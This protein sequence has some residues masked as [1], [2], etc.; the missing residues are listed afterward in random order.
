M[1]SHVN[2]PTSRIGRAGPSGY[3]TRDLPFRRYSAVL[4]AGLLLTLTSTGMVAQE[5]YPPVE[6]DDGFPVLPA[7]KSNQESLKLPA[8][9][10]AKTLLTPFD[11]S[12][13]MF[14]EIA[15][16]NTIHQGVMRVT[17]EGVS[18]GSR[19]DLLVM[20]SP[21]AAND[22]IAY[23]VIDDGDGTLSCKIFE[24]KVNWRVPIP[25]LLANQECTCQGVNNVIG[26][27]AEA[28]A[29]KNYQFLPPGLK[30]RR[31]AEYDWYW[32]DEETKL[33]VRAL[34]SRNNN[35]TRLPVL[36]EYAMAHFA[37]VET[38]APGTL[39]AVVD[40]CTD[41]QP[42][43]T[44]AAPDPAIEGVHGEM[45][46]DFELPVWPEKV[47]SN[48]ALTAVDGSFTSMAIYYDYAN[49]QEVS[50]ILYPRAWPN[51]GV[52]AGFIN[53]TRL[54]VSD[55]LEISIPEGQPAQCTSILRN[56]GIW[57]P[58]WAARD[59]CGCKA[60][61][62]AGTALNPSDVD[63]HAMSCFFAGKSRIDAW[64]DVEGGPHMFYESN[65]GDLDLIDYYAFDS[66]PVF[67]T[68]IF[69]HPRCEGVP[70][71]DLKST[72]TTCH[73]RVQPGQ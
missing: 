39:Q 57:H 46:Q 48:G 38:S 69:D 11:D 52:K 36:G 17:M 6:I 44:A 23:Q 24:E 8:S 43:I 4:A 51:V 49:L 64:Y 61:I 20:N 41:D 19:R 18:D 40:L 31:S 34:F 59:G 12:Q 16:D 54:T 7:C 22:A 33:P 70:I 58:N 50:R 73:G 63:M 29:C 25:D 5:Q 55:T 2:S 60:G 72:C 32:M 28:W 27:N 62:E 42:H 13:L 71:T 3:V 21:H 15:V 30:G 68:D 67:P 9:W 56:V 65:A 45:C 10:Q 66:S 47:Y 37:N 35:T 53:D 14:A 26:K 1:K